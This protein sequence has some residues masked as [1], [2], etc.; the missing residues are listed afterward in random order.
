[1][2]GVGQGGLDAADPLW[3]RNEIREQISDGSRDNGAS[4]QHI[5]YG[6]GEIRVVVEL[7]E[8]SKADAHAGVD[9]V[10]V[11]VVEGPSLGVCVEE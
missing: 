7:D 6:E 11:G 10:E 9:T 1:M 8:V 2:P 3:V 5:H 4:Q